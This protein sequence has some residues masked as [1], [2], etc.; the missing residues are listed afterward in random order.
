MFTYEFA[1]AAA[2]VTAPADPIPSTALGPWFLPL[3]PALVRIGLDHEILDR[4]EEVSFLAQ[5][6][7]FAGD[8]RML[9]VRYHEYLNAPLLE[10]CKC[11]PDRKTAND[12]LACNRA[13]RAD[14]AARMAL[15]QLHA[16]ELRSAVF[17][18]DLL[19]NVWECVRDARCDYYYVTVR[20]QSL[21]LLRQLVGNHAFYSGQL[22]PHVP[23][24]RFS[25]N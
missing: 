24:W 7:S 13:Y 22:P 21:S 1:L 5:S 10:E 17:E 15:D 19:H 20:R 2:L 11:F 12:F 16:E 3:R 4:R 23:V 8:L 6:E 25:Q 18:T 14:L 9:Q